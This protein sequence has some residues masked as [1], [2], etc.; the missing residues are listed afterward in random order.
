MT[1][2]ADAGLDVQGPQRIANLRLTAWTASTDGAV[3]GRWMPLLLN[4]TQAKSWTLATGRRTSTATGFPRCA[5]ATTSAPTIWF[6]TAPAPSTPPHRTGGLAMPSSPSP[7]CS[8]TTRSR[9]RGCVHRSQLRHRPDIVVSNIASSYGLEESNNFAILSTGSGPL[10][11]VAPYYDKS[12]ALGLSCSGWAW[13]V[14]AVDFDG[15][16]T[17]LLIQALGFIA[18][19]AGAGPSCCIGSGT[20]GIS[21]WP[22]THQ[23]GVARREAGL[24]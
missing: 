3:H 8:A 5:S 24:A 12:E 22:T 11:K 21:S 10:E 14:E 15:D 2:H 20:A 13:D 1:A 18:G 6:S 7:R 4:E 19:T 17:D 16:G 9:A 23:G